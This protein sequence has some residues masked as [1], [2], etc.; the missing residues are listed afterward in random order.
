MDLLPL[1]RMAPLLLLALLLG[2]APAQAED[3]RT[4]AQNAAAMSDS[5]DDEDD[6][7]AVRETAARPFDANAAADR[8]V[9]APG[10]TRGAK[11]LSKAGPGAREPRVEPPLAVEKKPKSRISSG[12]V[13]AGAAALGGL[14]GWFAA[15]MLGAVAGAGLGLAAAYLFHK[16]DYGAAFGVT[17]GAIIGTAF[18]G[19]IGGL[20]GAVVGGVIGHFL[21]KL[22]G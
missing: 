6:D 18:G 1:D 3:A 17:A 9:V 22:F 14:Q 10:V 19:P 20:I 4:Q 15:G 8:T 5:A 13:M 21:G 7:D 11:P 12:L 2:P 16:K